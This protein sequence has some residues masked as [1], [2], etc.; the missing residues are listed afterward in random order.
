MRGQREISRSR[1]L[2]GH[3]HT[4]TNA[5]D[6]PVRPCPG[7][8]AESIGSKSTA[9]TTRSRSVPG[10]EALGEILTDA[11]SMSPWCLPER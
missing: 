11:P 3:R 8:S 7:V 5:S 9:S 2:E 6:V 10:R 1:D 4:S